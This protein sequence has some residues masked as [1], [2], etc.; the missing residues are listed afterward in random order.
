MLGRVLLGGSLG[1]IPI[2]RFGGVFAGLGAI[3]FRGG[4]IGLWPVA[5]DR[6]CQ[7]VAVGRKTS[8]HRHGRGSAKTD[9]ARFAGQRTDQCSSE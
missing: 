3:L 7:P 1:S 2:V 6:P 4:R 5:G 8:L 9:R